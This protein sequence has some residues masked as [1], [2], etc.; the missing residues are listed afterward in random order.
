MRLLR[1]LHLALVAARHVGHVLRPVDV[2]GLRPRGVQPRLRQR[3]RVGPHIGDVAV[4]VQPLRDPH[5]GL[6][7]HPQLAAG[8]LLQGRGHERR[9]RPAYVGLVLDRADRE[10]RLAQ[11]VGEGDRGRLVELHA[12]EPGDRLAVP[13]E[14]ATGGDP[15]T[16][17][18]DQPG[19][20]PVGLTL[21]LVEGGLDVPVLRGPERDA[22]P[23]PLDDQPGRDR[24]HPAGR[25][26]LPDL[27]PQHRRDLVAVEPVQD[28][29][30]LLGVDQVQVEVAGLLDGGPDRVPGDLVEHHPA[31]RDLGVEHLQQVPGDGLALAV[32]VGREEQLVRVLERPLELG[33]LLLLVGVD[34]VERLEVGV[35]VDGELAEPALLLARRQLG[36]RRQV[37]DVA[38]AGLDVV[39]RAEV[40]LDRL[41]LGLRLDDHQPAVAG[42]RLVLRGHVPACP[43]VVRQRLRTAVARLRMATAVKPMVSARPPRPAGA[44]G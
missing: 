17:H 24:L 14:V 38:D 26:A 25:Q 35:H 5:G 37:A 42:L 36:G 7:G 16:V 43:V 41:R 22:L 18:R 1:V 8:L 21:H 4:L 34:D 32:L 2:P 29:P 9:G 19:I 31:D 28:A 20:E 30:G 12:V 13:A 44:P 3:R 6:R 40:A 27:A 23:L 15:T 11:P 39:A 10:V 33:D